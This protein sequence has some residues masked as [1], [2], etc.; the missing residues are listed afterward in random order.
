M[1]EVIITGTTPAKMAEIIQMVHINTQKGLADT[2]METR[3]YMTD[4]IAGGADGKGKREGSIGNLENLIQAEK[5]DDDSY[6][7]G[8]IGLLNQENG[9]RYWLLLNNGGMVALKAQ[10]VPGFFDSSIRRP[11]GGL[12]NAKEM[13]VYAPRGTLAFSFTGTDTGQGKYMMYVKNPIKPVHYIE[14]TK[15]WLKSV[16]GGKFSAMVNVKPAMWMK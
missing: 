12:M 1:I 14:Q 15:N 4:I 16:M 13:F 9:A 7:V 3:K 6:G 8:N 5:I 10:K 2:A 11:T